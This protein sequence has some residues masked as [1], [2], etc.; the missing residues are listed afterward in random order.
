MAVGE[1]TNW[2]YMFLF[3]VLG[4]LSLLIMRRTVPESPRWLLLKNRFGE[5]EQIIVQI[6]YDVKNDK[7]LFKPTK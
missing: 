4:I 5:S 1:T 3:G 6:E 2:R 7:F